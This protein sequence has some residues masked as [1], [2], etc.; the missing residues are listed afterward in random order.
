MKNYQAYLKLVEAWR[1]L[2]FP[3]RPSKVEMKIFDKLMEKHRGKRLLI[4]GATPEFRDLAAKYRMDTTCA[5]IN[6]QMLKGMRLLMKRQAKKEKLI[7]CNWLDMPFNDNAFDV[8]FAEQSVNIIA[9]NKFAKFFQ[10]TKRVLKPSG[11]LILKT[12]VP[13][14][15]SDYKVIKIYRQKK[16]SIHF[17]YDQLFHVKKRYSKSGQASHRKLGRDFG[18]LLKQ[19]KITQKDYDQ[20]FAAWGAMV[21]ADLRLNVMAKDKLEKLMK[22]YFKIKSILFGKDKIYHRLH[23]IYVLKK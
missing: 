22:K 19:S 2:V 3:A 4:L 15:D 21:K 16:Y 17:L 8:V 1:Q 9:T 6:P 13:N 18:T 23:P 12:A 14:P 5:D 7:K 20:F 11:D 10:E